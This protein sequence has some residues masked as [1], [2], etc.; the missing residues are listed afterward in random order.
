[1][2]GGVK[3]KDVLT[4][5]RTRVDRSQVLTSL[6]FP[7]S[8]HHTIFL[9]CIRERELILDLFESLVGARLLYGF[10][11]VGGVRYDLPPGWPE[12][13]RE[14]VDVYDWSFDEQGVVFRAVGRPCDRAARAVLTAERWTRG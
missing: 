5:T 6:H 3:S 10:Y 8:R 1:M 9:Y 13:C 11:Q 2:F 7:N 14:T 4:L 12:K